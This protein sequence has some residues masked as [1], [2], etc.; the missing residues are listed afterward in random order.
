M[1]PTLRLAAFSLACCCAALAA[2][3]A[4]P[5]D[6]DIGKFK[7]ADGQEFV[8]VNLGAPL[9]KI[10]SS[11]VNRNDP[12]CGALI[13]NLKHVR[14]NVVG[15]DETNRADT[16]DRVQTLRRELEAQG[17]TQAVTARPAGHTQDVAIYVKTA[18]DDS[19]EGLVVTVLDAESKQA[20]FVNVVG[21]IRP[22]QIAELGEGLDI[23]CL[24]HLPAPAA[25]KR[26]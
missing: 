11:I 23:D 3:A 2:R 17:W 12:K 26:S 5:G 8:E 13:A 14:V 18:A 19:I 20:V 1:H 24:A 21:N 6:V 4:D 25:A 10:A 16:T 22:D 7:P 9:L 15:Y